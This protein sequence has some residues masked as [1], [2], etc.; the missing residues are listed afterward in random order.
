[1]GEPA[2]AIEPENIQ[3]DPRESIPL[4]KWVRGVSQDSSSRFAAMQKAGS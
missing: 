2:Q 4:K 1:M 3:F